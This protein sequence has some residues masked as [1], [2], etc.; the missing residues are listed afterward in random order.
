MG[1]TVDDMTKVVLQGLCM[2]DDALHEAETKILA[3]CEKED[4]K[5]KKVKG[6]SYDKPISLASDYLQDF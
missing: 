1:Q 2:N 3:L 6:P 4:V 5:C